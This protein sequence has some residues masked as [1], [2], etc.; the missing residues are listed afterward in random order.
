MFALFF[1]PVRAYW[2]PFDK[3]YYLNVFVCVSTLHISLI[4]LERNIYH[5][6]QFIAPNK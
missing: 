1:V 5:F 6:V 3:I 2:S 4:F